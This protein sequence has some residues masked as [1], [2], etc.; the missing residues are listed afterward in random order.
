M[1]TLRTELD[2][3]LVVLKNKVSAALQHLPCAS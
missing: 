3:Y 1:D 2:D